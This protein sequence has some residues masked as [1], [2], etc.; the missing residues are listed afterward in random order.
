MR[1]WGAGARSRVE[2]I[3]SLGMRD[4]RKGSA[5]NPEDRIAA[6]RAL[7][8]LVRFNATPRVTLGLKRLRS[9][10][11]RRNDALGTYTTPLH[12]D[13]SNGADAFSEYAINARVI[14]PVPPPVIAR[15]KE[16]VFMMTPFGLRSN[17]TVEETIAAEL[18]KIERER[19]ED[20]I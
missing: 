3:K 5:M 14:V 6:V 7:L 2:T 11:R 12:N 15:P 13:D 20:T 18:A 8:P 16:E 9:Y 19:L 10:K 17:M 1:E 4:I